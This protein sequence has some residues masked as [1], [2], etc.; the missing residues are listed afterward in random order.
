[1]ATA[2]FCK[3][4]LSS[5]NGRCAKSHFLNRTDNDAPGGQTL[6]KS[7]RNP[8]RVRRE[9][10]LSDDGQATVIRMAGIG[11]RV[12]V[13]VA[14]LAAWSTVVVGGFCISG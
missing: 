14:F 10:K 2:C 5:F 9:K 13:V 11:T 7:R 1:M 3:V 6:T 8:L 12:Y 4:C